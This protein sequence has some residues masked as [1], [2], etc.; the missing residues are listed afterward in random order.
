MNSIKKMFCL[1]YSS[2]NLFLLILILLIPQH[3]ELYSQDN[4][5]IELTG[6][7]AKSQENGMGTILTVSKKIT[8]KLFLTASTGY[9]SFENSESSS[10]PFRDSDLIVNVNR[11]KFIIPLEIGGIIEFGQNKFKPYIK[12]SVSYNYVEYFI[13][14]DI[15]GGDQSIG[16]LRSE[17]E[18]KTNVLP[19]YG[20]G[21]GT[22]YLINQDIKIGINFTMQQVSNINRYIRLMAGISYII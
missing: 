14:K 6:G 2:L 15:F 17:M 16:Y 20:L 7:F 19:G 3:G 5:Y 9:F 21:M 11:E 13:H 12:F 1:K 8:G 10:N 22:S 18:Y 4:T